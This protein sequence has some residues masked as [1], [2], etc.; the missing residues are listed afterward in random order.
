MEKNHVGSYRVRQPQDRDEFLDRGG[1]I[2]DHDFQVAPHKFVEVEILIFVLAG[3]WAAVLKLLVTPVAPERSPSENFLADHENFVTAHEMCLTSAM[4]PQQDLS[5]HSHLG[6]LQMRR[7][8]VTS[9]QEVR[10]P[11][12][13]AFYP[14]FG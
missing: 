5:R 13:V 9:R 3:C 1:E 4:S 14:G 6:L 11:A 2:Q 10:C 12:R 7:V 8:P